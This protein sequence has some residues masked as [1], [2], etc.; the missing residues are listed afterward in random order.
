MSFGSIKKTFFMLKNYFF[1][2][3]FLLFS[4]SIFA[5]QK[6]S[7]TSSIP[8][9]QIKTGIKTNQIALRW[10]V[11]EPL[12][13]QKANKIGF[14]L[15]RYT[16]MRDGQLLAKPELK[17]LGVFLPKP[18]KDWKSIIETNDKAA[19]IA[20]A[21]YGESFEVEMGSQGELENIIINPKK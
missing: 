19:I 2:I 6:E 13:W 9:I 16:L 15:K 17:D 18:V 1:Y 14:S 7:H 20:Q 8:S 3:F 4:F 11:D 5:Q 21:L 12:A 10:A